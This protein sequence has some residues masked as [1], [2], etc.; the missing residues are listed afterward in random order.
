VIT[1]GTLH[2]RAAARRALLG[3]VLSMGRLTAVD[4]FEPDGAD[5]K[6]D[7]LRPAAN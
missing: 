7:S 1:S 2:G 4:P 5:A 6:V 3:A